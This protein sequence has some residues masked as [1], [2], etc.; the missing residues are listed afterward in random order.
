MLALVLDGKAKLIPDYPRPIPTHDEALIKVH[1]A[2]ICSTDLQLV[3]GYKGFQGV[4]GHEF[5]GSVVECE[6]DRWV[7]RRVVGEINI[8][9]GQCNFCLQ[10][11]VSHCRKR[12]AIG[13]MGRD[14]AFAQFLTLPLVN[15]HPVPESV[16]DQGAVFAEPLAAAAQILTQVEI[17][18]DDRVG[19]LGDGKLGLLVAQVMA[20]TGAWVTV[21]GH[22]PSKLALVESW[23]LSTGRPDNHLDLVVECTG[24]AEGLDSALELIRPRGTV[25]LKSTY[26]QSAPMN[27]TK[28]VVDEIQLIGSRCGPI[29]RALGLLQSDPIDVISLIEAHYPLVQGLKALEHAGRRGVLKVLIQ[30]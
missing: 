30:P 6:D 1:L 29:D 5:V 26:H 14:G 24:S 20:K 19:I 11:T 28:A 22:H 25:V 18:P 9:C 12:K 8:G 16:P 13:I 7:G 2:G 15:L 23:G 3:Q 10:G 21:I 4:L 27:L 17:A